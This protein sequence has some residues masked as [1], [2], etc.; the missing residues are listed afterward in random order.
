M[1]AEFTNYIFPPNTG[2]HLT[3]KTSVESKVKTNLS[4][5]SLFSS[6]TASAVVFHNLCAPIHSRPWLYCHSIYT[7]SDHSSIY[8]APPKL[9]RESSG[10]SRLLGSA[11]NVV[12]PNMESRNMLIRQREW[13][14]SKVVRYGNHMILLSS[15]SLECWLHAKD[16]PTFSSCSCSAN[17]HVIWHT[18]SHLQ[19]LWVSSWPNQHVFGLWEETCGTRRANGNSGLEHEHDRL[20][21][22]C[23]WEAAAKP[24]NRSVV[25]P[26][27]VGAWCTDCIF[28]I[29]Q[30]S[31]AQNEKFKQHKWGWNCKDGD[32]AAQILTRKSHN[33]TRH[34]GLTFDITF[35]LALII[36][37]D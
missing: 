32:V 5:W 17:M 21:G 10:K 2:Q 7:F 33:G 4:F 12:L 37:I 20:R 15:D 9:V 23:F 13:H 22:P 14:H 11:E 1:A 34:V 24:H 29:L 19:A 3:M 25:L 6:C 31:Q 35:V 27:T 16:I 30:F 18:H 28:R 8:C 36:Y 26:N